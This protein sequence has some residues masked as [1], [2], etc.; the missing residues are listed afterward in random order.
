MT[1]VPDPGETDAAESDDASAS[2]RGRLLSAGVELML[3]RPIG[4]GLSHV[5]ATEVSRRAGLSHGAFYHHWPSQEDFQEE[6]FEHILGLGRNA[7][8]V[9]SF[10]ARMAEVDQDEPAESIRRAMNSSFGEVDLI[11]WRLWVAL[12]ARNDPGIDE[13]LGERYRS[14]SEAYIPN[15]EAV[16]DEL[17]L[18]TRAPIDVERLVILV[19][20]LW[21]GLAL[22]RTVAPDLV[23]GQSAEDEHGRTWTLYALGVA[24]MLLGA[25]EPH[26]DFDGSLLDAIRRFVFSPPE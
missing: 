14:V 20:A 3:E 25:L 6:L 26:G 10:M 18:R 22:R 23:D 8:E 17:G 4:T 13:R 11:P 19:D 1:N 5:K 7:D 16:F 21:E 12:V 15:V 24:A 9:A 2:T